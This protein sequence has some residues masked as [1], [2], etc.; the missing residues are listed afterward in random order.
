MM[1][2][3]AELLGLFHSITKHMS[4]R[5]A[6]SGDIIPFIKIQKDYVTDELTKVK[7][8]GLHTTLSN[9]KDSFDKRYSKY[10]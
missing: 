10:D 3:V 5:Y 9:L 7:F 1:E 2:K 6:N 4:H 8:T